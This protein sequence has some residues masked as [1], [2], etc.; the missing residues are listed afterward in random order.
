[1]FVIIRLS[2]QLV[3][4]WYPESKRDSS[5]NDSS[6]GHTIP[7]AFY[8]VITGFNGLNDPYIHPAGL[9]Y[10]SDNGY[11]PSVTCLELQPVIQGLYQAGTIQSSIYVPLEIYQACFSFSLCF[12]WDFSNVNIIKIGLLDQ[13]NNLSMQC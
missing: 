12:W 8:L 11:L 6:I 4:T 7:I 10:C 9:P 5:P 13:R 2:I 1:M 3:L